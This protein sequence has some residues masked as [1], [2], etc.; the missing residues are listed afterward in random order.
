MRRKLL[1]LAVLLTLA[2]ACHAQ[3]IS[4]VGDMTAALQAYPAEQPAALA[5][6]RG[7]KAAPLR[8]LG[9]ASATYITT[10]GELRDALSLYQA[11]KPLMM[12]IGNDTYSVSLEL[13]EQVMSPDYGRAGWWDKHVEPGC[14]VCAAV[15]LVREHVVSSGAT[16]RTARKRQPTVVPIV[17]GESSRI[18][19][20]R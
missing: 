14:Q 3:T 9:N 16:D 1:A 10:A 11:S 20:A 2:P 4:T 13:V 8:I 6:G 5:I 18:E 7:F 15:V 19:A 12:A 17:L